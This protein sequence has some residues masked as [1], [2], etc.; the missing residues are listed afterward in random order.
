MSKIRKNQPH[1]TVPAATLPDIAPREG[2][3]TQAAVRAVI[4]ATV[5]LT[6]LALLPYTQDPARDSKYIVLHIGVAAAAILGLG[7]I[8]VRGVA[9]RRPALPGLILLGYLGINLAA[10]LASAHVANS[11]N[12]WRQ[13]ATLALLFFLTAA[14]FRT[15][16]QAMRL[17]TAACAALAMS[18]VYGLCQKMGWDPFPWADRS[19]EEYRNLPATYGNP[20]IAAHALTL[21]LIM[22]VG[23]AWVQMR[24]SAAA[25]IRRWKDAALPAAMAILM[26]AHIYFT[27]ARAAIVALLAAL[28]LAAIATAIARAGRR[29]PGRNVVAALA[30]LALAGMAAAG[31]AAG[32]SKARTGSWLPV[33]RSLLLRYHGYYGAARMAAD[34]PLFGYGPGNYHIDNPP[35]WT[36]F[37]RD[38]FA[39]KSMVNTNVH[40]EYLEAAV[41]GG[42]LSA[43]LYIGFLF[44]AI[45]YSL[46]MFYSTRDKDKRAL[47]L[48]L[49]AGFCAFAVDGLFGFNF[50]VPVS[51]MLLFV[52][53]GTL[54][55]LLETAALS[56]KTAIAVSAAATIAAL[57]FLV[58]DIRSFAASHYLLR[59]Q[60][61][62]VY[63]DMGAAKS[64]LLKGQKL[65]PWNFEFPRELGLLHM[66]REIRDP[67]A[68]IAYFEQAVTLH[69]NEVRQYMMLGLAH[70]N[71]VTAAAQDPA[72]REAAR[73][74]LQAAQD[75]AAKGLALC[76]KL[77]QVHELLGRLA[78]I[79]GRGMLEGTPPA[80]EERRK[81]YE[82]AATHFRDALGYATDK[83][84][85]ASLMM[86]EANIALDKL[87]DAEK[88][89]V[90]AAQVDAKNPEVWR[91]FEDYAT[92]AK[93]WPAFIAQAA[94]AL[95]NEKAQPQPDAAR[96]TL[97]A[98]S[99]G[100]AHAAAKQPDKAR[101]VLEEALAGDPGRLDL[102]AAYAAV[103]PEKER[104]SR[105]LA[106]YRK[107]QAQLPKGTSP[108]L[109]VLAALSESN[110]A[111]AIAAAATL[112]E[113]AIAHMQ[114]SGAATLDAQ[115]RWLA[116]LVADGLDEAAAVAPKGEDAE[117]GE[118]YHSAGFVYLMMDAWQ[119]ADFLLAQ[120][121]AFLPPGQ[122][123]YCQLH[124]SEALAKMTK[125]EE[126]LAVAQ[127]A[128]AQAPSLMQ[129]N[130][131]YAKLLALAGHKEEARR[132]YEM[133]IQ[134]PGIDEA[135]KR[136]IQGELDPL[137]KK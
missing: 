16:E 84:G 111:P 94:A 97:L 49:A 37:E 2:G 30:I 80:P 137:L 61:A 71:C 42:F 8:L 110:D 104:K 100:R 9:L 78:I 113:A 85:P 58:W 107:S 23:L 51:A 121:L 131:Q 77:P 19:V 43:G 65:E 86:A 76:P 48:T 39:T 59:A 95:K 136:Q 83:P 82:E 15:P 124:R 127:E 27:Q 90:H 54:A 125:Y 53:A 11:L 45:A 38:R 73:N 115:Y 63:K 40:N 114:K 109:D 28:A 106:L 134:S 123:V 32:M 118:A 93:R 6:V 10:A 87:D 21:G 14:A 122:Q 3:K 36:V 20:N 68:A 67:N 72:G 64:A 69:P 22:A 41:E 1:S 12:A 135:S 62:A 96:I 120:A 5:I 70:V 57:I 56:R 126:A 112:R 17:V 116:G 29:T 66:S 133:L 13:Y 92:K 98:A 81:A 7:G 119:E 102:W 44:S 88:M 132:E 31:L 103:L 117:L 101:A 26:A 129:T 74:H 46:W 25:G 108:G 18:S 33:D 52:L 50:R 91:V 34:H 75:A 105:I 79:R 55:G 35:Y 60:G 89:L 4:A 128:R 24:N 47:A 99:L 130:F